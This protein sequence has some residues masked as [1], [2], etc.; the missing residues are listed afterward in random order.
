MLFTEVL[1]GAWE[2]IV[3]SHIGGVSFTVEWNKIKDDSAGMKYPLAAW[4]PVTTALVERAEVLQD[5]YTVSLA[6][7]D[8]TASGRS[9]DD[10][11]QAHSRMEMIAKQCFKRFHA[12]YIADN[13]SYQGEPMDME[14]TADVVFSPVW[15][16]EAYM[17]TGVVMSFTVASRAPVECLDTFFN[18]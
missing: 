13:G 7:L 5:T 1:R 18:A 2:D 11:L 4:K 9:A 16:S 10:M 3:T 6:F 17:R 8:R 12:L 14:L 15:D